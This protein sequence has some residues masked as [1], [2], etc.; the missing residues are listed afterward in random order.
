[1]HPNI[2]SS[3]VHNSQTVEGA[4][5]SFNRWMD[6]ADVVYM[7]W[8]TTQQS[9][10]WNLAICKDVGGTGGYYA[11]WNK[12]IR[13]KQLPDDLTHMWNLR[14][15]TEEHGEEREKKTRW[16]LRGRQTLRGWLLIMETN[17]GSLEGRGMGRWGNWGMGIKE[18]TWC[19]EHWV[20][21]ATDESLNSTSETNKV[22][23][24]G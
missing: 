17:Q 11:K 16:N 22:L 12:S 20:L 1:M 9:K 15:K 6:K 18:G 13:E 19:N 23:Y 10:K 5:M 2:H 24:V 21:Y 7:Q 8:K 14:N 4:E 3:T